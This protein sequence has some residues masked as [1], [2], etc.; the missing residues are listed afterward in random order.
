[1]PLH[2]FADNLARMIW[3]CR[4]LAIG[5]ALSF[6]GLACS[7]IPMDEQQGMNTSSP[8]GGASTVTS[9]GTAGTTGG[10]TSHAG[11][12]GTT[13]GATGTIGG[14]IVT[15]GGTSGSTGGTAGITG[16]GGNKCTT[17]RN[18][19][20]TDA[21]CTTSDYG[22]PLLSPTDCYCFRCGG[23]VNNAIT[24]DCESAYD[25]FCGPDWQ[26]EHGCE[27]PPCAPTMP[28]CVSGVCWSVVDL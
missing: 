18:T 10:I 1:M 6:T 17:D 9:G 26:Q 14:T 19:C 8:S 24:A 3:K 15:S 23:G 4:W 11:T 13:G 7:R 21:D 20:V 28:A 22:P 12:T 2:H 5:L 27:P 25:Q 16:T